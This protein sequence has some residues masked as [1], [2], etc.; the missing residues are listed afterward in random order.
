LERVLT[1]CRF[2]TL[3]ELERGAV[4]TW[5]VHEAKRMKEGMSAR[6]RNTYL[7]SLNAFANWCIET[8]RLALNPFD[9]VARADER[10]DRRRQ[11]RSMTEAELVQLLDV[12]RRR[13][14]LEALTVRTGKR[15][16][17][18]VANV[19]PEVRQG[20]EALGRER[21]LIYKTL[22]LTGLRL[23]ELST[24]SV[25]K[26]RLDGRVAFAELDAA[27]EKN[28]EGNAVP[29]RDDLAADLRDWLGD[30][31]AL[32]QADVRRRGEPIPSRLPAEAR[33]FTVPKELVKILNRDL[34]LAGISKT[35]DRGRTIDVYALQTTFGT[36][37]SKGGVAP[38]T[39]QAAMRHSDVDFAINEKTR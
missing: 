32:L 30:R 20:L 36:L 26:L 31:L 6:T 38:R 5:L 7:M 14:L 10:A 22:V 4:E 25:R 1:D 3:A 28:R 24:L 13:P 29:I 39:A 18:A 9:L 19:R 33:V 15:T 23:N 16:G 21:G 8:G 37:L 17:Q 2:T 12:T 35:D 27:D 11:R 34:K